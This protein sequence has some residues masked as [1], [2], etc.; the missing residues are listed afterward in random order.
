MTMIEERALR[1]ALR[2]AAESIPVPDQGA[3]QILKA[4]QRLDTRLRIGSASRPHRDTET[5]SSGS[6]DEPRTDD[7]AARPRRPRRRVLA[8]AA[9]VTAVLAISLGAFVT[10]HGAGSSNLTASSTPRIAVGRAP[11]VPNGHSSGSGGVAYG[12]LAGTAG[13]AQP[14][15]PNLPTGAVGQS[16]EVEETGE[17]DL[18]VGPGQLGP[19]LT[20][21]TNLAAAQGGFVASTQV[22]A[23]GASA[24]PP[25]SGSITLQ[26]PEA[27]FGPVVAQVR[28]LGK[29][30]LLTTKGTD[31]TGQYVDLQARIAAL[32][33]SRQ[34][35]LTIMTKASSI[36]DI[37]AVQA[38][39]DSLQTQIEQLQG[40][41][42]V[43]TGETTYGTLVVA[44][45][46]HAGHPAPV[47][48][49]PSGID[50]AWHGALSGF[51]AAFDGLIR[52]AG[53]ALFVLLCVAALAVLGRWAW[54]ET[55]RR[56]L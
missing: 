22:E 53:P 55:R 40:Q 38:Q 46:E 48:H 10:L 51:A 2:E 37:L 25:S 36:S 27:S 33:A 39:L 28:T 44:L 9:A 4:A 26:V 32:T 52:I 18:S 47:H 45:S 19:V 31:V 15:T 20:R 29:V 35:Y 34:Q 56:A 42:Q 21:L 8:V 30:T 17:V 49:R 11:A 6:P 50:R 43:L 14:T 1:A 23:G 3:E 41:L 7:A 24:S 16:S 12:P 13:G 54:R 5:G